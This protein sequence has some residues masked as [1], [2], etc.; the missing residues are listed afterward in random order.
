MAQEIRDAAGHLIGYELEHTA[1]H[2]DD[3]CDRTEQL[4][5]TE[6]AVAGYSQSAQSNAQ[7][8]AQSA[9]S[10]ASDKTAAAQSASQAQ[11]SAAQAAADATATETAK[12]AAQTAKTAAESARDRA[13][14]AAS[15]AE[16]AKTDALN[17][18]AAAE[19]ASSTAV[20]AATNASRSETS[21]STD[22]SRAEAAAIRA[23][24]AAEE[25]EE[26]ASAVTS[27]NGQTGTVVLTKS[28]L[29]LGNVDNTSDANK[30]ISTAT[31]T[32]LN[33]KLNTSGGTMSGALAMGSNRITGLAAGVN[34]TD[35]VTKS[36]METYINS[37]D[38][39]EVNF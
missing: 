9:A 10:A 20:T 21:A 11:S 38:V 30:P 14:A 37:L 5:Q 28:D 13:E 27:V 26:H 2:V 4:E 39:S 29:N 8:A 17:A 18:Q 15:T 6:T 34:G 24:E 35:A 33:G 1:Q 7:A 32:A 3:M 22:A 25:A 31:Q 23:E 36:Q 19:T 16:G 12:T